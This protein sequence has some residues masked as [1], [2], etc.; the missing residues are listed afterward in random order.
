M[1]I[2]LLLFSVFLCF[3]QFTKAQIDYPVLSEFC[4]DNAHLFSGDEVLSLNNKLKNFET[5]TSHQIV[6]LTVNSLDNISVEEYALRVFEAND[7]GQKKLDN[8]V[9][10]LI[11]KNDK[12]FRV[13]VGYGL[14]P[15]ITDALSSRITRNIMTPKFKNNDFYEGIDLATD[16][17]IL[18]INDPIYAEEFASVKE[19]EHN[20]LPLIFS[21]LLFCVIFVVLGLF[22][23]LGGRLFL[24]GFKKL[25][26]VYRGFITGKISFIFFP[27]L[28]FGVLFIT[29]V[30]T[31]FVIMPLIFAILIGGEIFF[32]TNVSEY[33]NAFSSSGLL[34]IPMLLAFVGFVILL[35]PFTLALIKQKKGLDP[36]SFSWFKTDHRY[37]DK[38]FPSSG[39]IGGG[40]G[41]SRSY[42]SSSSSSS[43]SFSGGGGRSG[44]GGSS[45]GW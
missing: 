12:K 6:V 36:M 11:A 9:L 8:G 40:G 35:L 30:S 13:E 34:T 7:I 14:E 22:I 43:S 38:Y 42:S 19:D 28:L 37:M 27:F 31:L 5:E 1:K 32:N 4:T 23:Y 45:G 33:F 21:I 15:I 16:E 3:I 41:S 18:L 39:S 17:I 26:H 10:I 20:T 2:K 29:I 25:I 44:G 24:F